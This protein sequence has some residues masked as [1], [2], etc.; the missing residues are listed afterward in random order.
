MPVALL[1]EMAARSGRPVM[2]A[3]LLH[4]GTN[5]RRGVRRPRRHQR[6][7][8]ARPPTDRAGVV[9]PA[10]DGLHA[11]L[12]LPGRRPGELEARARPAGRA[13][14]ARCSPTQAFRQ[15]VRAEL[16]APSTFRLFNGEWDKVHVVEVGAAAPSR[17]GAAQRRRHRAARRART[18]STRCST[19][20]STRTWTTIFTAQLLNSDEAAVARLLNHPHSLISLSRRRRAPDLLQRRRL[21]PAPAGPLG[22]RARRRCACPRR[23]GG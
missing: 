11:G 9:L 1:E 3:A 21:R 7:Q 23:C 4:N 2:I 17:A 10:D 6:R 5:P 15:G 8:R 13:R 18:R 22:A 14:C 16:A 12:A 19:S 20:R